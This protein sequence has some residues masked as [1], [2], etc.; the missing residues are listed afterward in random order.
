MKK[1]T[2][3]TLLTLTMLTTAAV[4]VFAADNDVTIDKT[5]NTGSTNITYKVESTY[6]VVI[7]PSITLDTATGKGTIDVAVNK[8][9]ITPEE[10][11][12]VAISKADNSDGTTIFQ[13]KD[14]KDHFV[15]YTIDK[16]GTTVNLNDKFLSMKGGETLPSVTLNITATGTPKIA[17]DHTDKLTFTA[18]L[19]TTSAE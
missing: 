7:P 1:K 11:L 4:P 15:S 12:S 19:A 17:G 6:T 2:L 8:A 3:A 18:A 14:T 16:E 13:L 5:T 10:T 9:V